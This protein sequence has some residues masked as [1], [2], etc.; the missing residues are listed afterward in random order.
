MKAE[1]TNK[2]NWAL[3]IKNLFISTQLNQCRRQSPPSKATVF[4]D[5]SRHTHSFA[6]RQLSSLLWW[7]HRGSWLWSRCTR[8]ACSLLP[9]DRTLGSSLWTRASYLGPAGRRSSH[10][11]WRTCSSVYSRRPVL[12][13]RP[14]CTVSAISTSLPVVTIHRNISL[15]GDWECLWNLEM[16]AL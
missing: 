10:R 9:Q 1:K 11:T 5:Q 16:S 8:T 7:R 15:P 4:V 12:G 3:N 13:G 14:V 2:Q 6:A